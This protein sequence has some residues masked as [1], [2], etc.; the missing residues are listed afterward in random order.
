MVGQVNHEPVEAVRDRRACWTARRVVGPEHEV[1]HEELGAPLE[2]VCQRGTPLVSVESVFLVDPHPR[3]LLP[4]PRQLVAAP[5]E[6]LLRLEQREPLCGPLLV[7][8]L[9]PE[10]CCPG[11]VLRHRPHTLRVS[12]RVRALPSRVRSTSAAGADHVLAS[13]SP[14]HYVAARGPTRDNAAHLKSGYQSA[15]KE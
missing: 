2:E 1:V 6:L 15:G 4:P 8:A 13:L 11:P 14:R 7:P 3:Q 9:V 5:R 12:F 10:A